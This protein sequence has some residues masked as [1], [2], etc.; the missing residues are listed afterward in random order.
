MRVIGG[1]FRSRRLKSLRGQ[2]T[3]PTSDKLRETLFDVLGPAVAGS[4]WYDCFAGSGAV[5][6]EALSRG[7]ASVVFIERGAAAVRVLRQNIDALG[8]GSRCSVLEQAVT[9]A[10]KRATRAADFFFLDPPYDASIEYRRAL[11]WLGQSTLL[12]PQAT[13]IA[14]HS[15]RLPLEA[16]YGPLARSRV[17]EQGDSS[18]SFY[19]LAAP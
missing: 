16:R 2:A 9:M 15:R 13:V 11:D 6:L 3:R 10:L 18:L 5:G 12:R 7:A 19:R 14:E 1:E 17:L 4:V 8:L